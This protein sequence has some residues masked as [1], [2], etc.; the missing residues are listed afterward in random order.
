MSIPLFLSL[1]TYLLLPLFSLPISLTPLQLVLAEL[2]RSLRLRWLRSR[3]SFFRHRRQHW[4]SERM[5]DCR[6]T[7]RR[8]TGAAPSLPHPF[9]APL[10]ST[11]STSSG[12]GDGELAQ[13]GRHLQ[14][15]FH[16]DTGRTVLFL[17]PNPPSFSLHLASPEVPQNSWTMPEERTTASSKS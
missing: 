1:S 14:F 13:P 16:S 15:R 6:T 11:D 9:A 3:I 5:A 10:W 12:D 2:F 17:S 7:T 8:R 4:L